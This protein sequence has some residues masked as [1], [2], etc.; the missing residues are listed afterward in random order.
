MGVGISLIGCYL[1]GYVWYLAQSKSVEKKMKK[2]GYLAA[3]L[4]CGTAILLVAHISLSGFTVLLNESIG[5]L[6]RMVVRK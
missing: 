5:N 1:L 3:A 6:T 2:W 4:A